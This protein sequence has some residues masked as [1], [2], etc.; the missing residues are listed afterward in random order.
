VFRKIKSHDLWINIEMDSLNYDVD[1]LM[2][3]HGKYIQWIQ[4]ERMVHLLVTIFT[5]SCLLLSFYLFIE[6]DTVIAGILCLILGILFTFYIFHYFRL[7]N[8][9]QKWY[10]IYRLLWLKKH[11]GGEQYV[12]E[13]NIEN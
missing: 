8:T 11:N 5:G 3:F 6:L 10:D 9:T 13:D 7:E 1:E 4:H 12:P 2:D